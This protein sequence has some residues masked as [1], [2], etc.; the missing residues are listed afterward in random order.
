MKPYNHPITAVYKILN[1]NIRDGLI[2]E[3]QK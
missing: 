3:E 1:Y 2:S